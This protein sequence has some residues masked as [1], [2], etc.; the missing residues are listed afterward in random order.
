MPGLFFVRPFSD[1]SVFRRQGPES[2]RFEG[3]RAKGR[4]PV[5]TIFVVIPFNYFE[6]AFALRPCRPRAPPFVKAL[7]GA[8]DAE[9]GFLIG[10]SRL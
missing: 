2:R 10:P 4:F 9:G 3:G 5:A 8:P 1:L 6:N 7:E